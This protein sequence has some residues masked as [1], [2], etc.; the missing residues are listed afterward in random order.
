VNWTDHNVHDPGVTLLELFAFLGD[1][2]AFFSDEV[3]GQ[4]RRR[5]VGRYALALVPIG[6]VIFVCRRRTAAARLPA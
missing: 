3:A 1:A 6:A 2:L 5:I 4:R